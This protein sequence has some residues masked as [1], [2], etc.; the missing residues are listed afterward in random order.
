MANAREALSLWAELLTEKAEQMPAPRTLT[1]IK[2][3]PDAARDVRAFMIAL[4]PF[5][6]LLRAA[7]E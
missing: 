3:D 5:E 2:D 7:A 4:I 1:E 6:P